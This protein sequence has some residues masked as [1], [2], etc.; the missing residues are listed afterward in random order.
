M[1]TAHRVDLGIVAGLQVPDSPI[2]P[3]LWT[4]KG[5]YT[6]I[7][8]SSDCATYWVTKSKIR[9]PFFTLKTTNIWS[10]THEAFNRLAARVGGSSPRGFLGK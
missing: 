6:C 2:I 3:C 1:G 8:Q 9:I 7:P 4:H 5:D 10:M